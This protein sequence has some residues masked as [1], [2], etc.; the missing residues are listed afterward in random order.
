MGGDH[1]LANHDRRVLLA[2]KGEKLLQSDN[3]D[4]DD[5]D[6]RYTIVV[7]CEAGDE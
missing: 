3:D 5:Q 6:H 2:G 7:Q 1:H 4:P